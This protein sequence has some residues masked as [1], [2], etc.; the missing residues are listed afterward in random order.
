[1]GKYIRKTYSYEEIAHDFLGDEDPV[2]LKDGKDLL[3]AKD[4]KEAFEDFF[5]GNLGDDGLYYI[6]NFANDRW[7]PEWDEVTSYDGTP[8]AE[9]PVAYVEI[10]DETASI[11]SEVDCDID[12]CF[13]PGDSENEPPDL[14]I[15]GLTHIIPRHSK[16]R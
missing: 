12:W 15:T 6:D 16:G 2:F 7:D 8:E 1:M 10:G 14:R 13:T 4:V 5:N 9:R 3:S 11:S